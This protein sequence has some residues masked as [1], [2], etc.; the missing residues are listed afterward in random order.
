MRASQ[1][2]ILKHDLEY[3]LSQVSRAELIQQRGFVDMIL[4][5]YN[6]MENIEKAKLNPVS[7]LNSQLSD[8][9][10][11]DLALFNLVYAEILTNMIKENNEESNLKLGKV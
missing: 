8:H 10:Y 6:N 3:A 5:E 9:T 4:D 11:N 7:Y 2:E 1:F